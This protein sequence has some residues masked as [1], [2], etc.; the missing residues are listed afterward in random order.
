MNRQRDIDRVLD[1]WL[2]DG[3][4]HMPDRLFEAVLD[5]VE[6][7][8]QRHRPWSNLRFPP[9]TPRL[10]LTTA[11][12]IVVAVGAVGFAMLGG[13][14]P[15]TPP[16]GTPSAT[17]SSTPPVSSSPGLLDLGPREIRD[18]IWLAEPRPAEVLGVESNMAALVFQMGGLR[19]DTGHARIL[20]SD[21]VAGRSNEL[22]LTSVENPGGCAV[23]D[24]GRYQWSLSPGG[25]KLVLDH[26]QDDCSSRAAALPGEWLRVACP[27]EDNWCLGPLEPGR[28]A[29]QFFDPFVIPTDFRPRFGAL[30]YDVTTSGWENNQDWALE[31]QLKPAGSPDDTGIFLFSDILAVS[32]ADP[33]SQSPEPTVGRTA[34]E[35]VEWLTRATGVAATPPQPVTVG[36]L[37]GWRID[38]AMAPDWTGT[39]SWSDG[40]VTRPLF[41]DA[42]SGDGFYWGL[43]AETRMRLWLLAL[44][45]GRTLLVDIDGDASTYA[46]ILDEATRI[47]ESFEFK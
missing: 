6:R 18:Y 41:T 10:Y 25:T 31:Y 16:G 45:D 28:Y 14:S 37:A 17:P 46:A 35:I 11:A 19:F 13:P 20:T 21:V 38:V 8:P 27:N 9:M 44:P 26:I 23:G 30:S 3:S 12:A 33:C 40:E 39:C 7:T 24:V 42:D 36:G 22:V 5:R 4:S 2:V 43:G 47:V 1:A 15:V 29:S 34:D 32:E